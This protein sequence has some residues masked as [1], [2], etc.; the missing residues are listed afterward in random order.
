MTA[1]EPD[2][3]AKIGQQFIQAVPHMRELGIELLAIGGGE[4]R[5]RVPYDERFVGDPKTGVIH[6]GVLT[7]LLDSCCGAAVMSH[8]G[9]PAGTATIDL[10]IDYMRAARPGRAVTAHA[11]CYR[12]TRSVAFV[13]ALAFEDDPDDPVAAAHGAFTVER[14]ARAGKS[15]G[16]KA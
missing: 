5:M 9:G 8:P 7:A 4:A 10:R 3:Q 16:G 14:P 11:T 15:G 13:R 6:G 12:L 1:A 2:R